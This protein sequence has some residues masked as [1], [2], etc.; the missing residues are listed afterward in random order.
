MYLVIEN[1]HHEIIV[2][3]NQT[4]KQVKNLVDRYKGDKKVS[5]DVYKVTKKLSVDD[6]QT[7]DN[8]NS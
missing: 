7:T 1:N 5:Y 2:Y 6:F 4:K 8:P 3:E